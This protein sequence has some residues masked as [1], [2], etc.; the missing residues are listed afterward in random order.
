M[1]PCDCWTVATWVPK[2]HWQR[3]CAHKLVCSE[4]ATWVE[5]R[6]D[7]TSLLNNDC[8]HSKKVCSRSGLWLIWQGILGY[9]ASPSTPYMYLLTVRFIC[10]WAYV[11][12]MYLTSPNKQ[13]LKCPV[14]DSIYDDF[15][16]WL[17]SAIFVLLWP[18]VILIW[19]YSSYVN[20]C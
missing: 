14:S 6:T 7:C 5:H 17:I 9:V 3:I 10:V 13:Q 12:K 18:T 16:A 20:F 15:A 1:Y 19:H 8:T 4:N 2:F 11:A